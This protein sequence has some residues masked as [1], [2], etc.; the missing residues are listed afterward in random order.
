MLGGCGVR[1]AVRQADVEV[2]RFHQSLDEG[3]SRQIWAETGQ[4]MRKATTER[5]F[6]ATLD[7]VHRKLGRVRSSRQV[8]WQRNAS[9]KGSFTTVTNETVFEHGSGTERFV[10]LKDKAD[11]LALVGYHIEFDEMMRN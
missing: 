4:P 3:H 7:A 9:T 11:K 8:G 5:Q 2:A 1:D 10:F 6:L